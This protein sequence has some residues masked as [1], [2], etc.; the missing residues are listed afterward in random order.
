MTPEELEQQAITF[1][2]SNRTRIARKLTDKN[3][4]PSDI[5]PVSVFMSGSPGAGKT[6]TSKAFLDI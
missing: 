4:F 3:E 2:K 5:R 6:E 1:A